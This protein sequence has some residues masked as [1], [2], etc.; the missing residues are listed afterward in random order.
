MGV[1]KKEGGLHHLFSL[2]RRKDGLELER[3]K[4]NVGGG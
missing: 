2:W 4:P 3:C 1:G